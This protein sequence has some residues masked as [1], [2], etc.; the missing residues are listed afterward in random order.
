MACAAIGSSDAADGVLLTQNSFICPCPYAMHSELCSTLS[1]AQPLRWKHFKQPLPGSNQQ[2]LCHMITSQCLFQQ[3]RTCKPL[4][5][6]WERKHILT[7]SNVLRLW[8]LVDPLHA[9]ALSLQA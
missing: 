3:Y 9:E 7:P 1:S 8:H 6:Q 4:L 2:D 5:V